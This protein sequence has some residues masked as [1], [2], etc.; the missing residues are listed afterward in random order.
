MPELND[1]DAQAAGNVD[2]SVMPTTLDLLL[3]EIHAACRLVG[4]ELDRLEQLVA[5]LHPERARAAQ[6]AVILARTGI[7]EVGLRAHAKPLDEP[8]P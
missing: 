8:E 7:D 6:T 1:S 4:L 5:Q 2:P 3:A